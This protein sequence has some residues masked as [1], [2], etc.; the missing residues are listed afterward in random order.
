MNY[1]FLFVTI[2]NYKKL[3]TNINTRNTLIN[4]LKLYKIEAIDQII[5]NYAGGKT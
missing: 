1:F 4:N 3:R 2:N 5:N